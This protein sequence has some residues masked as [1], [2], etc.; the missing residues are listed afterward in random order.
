MTLASGRGC[1]SS[2]AAPPLSSATGN[3]SNRSFPAVKAGCCSPT[4]S[5]IAITPPAEIGSPTR[6]GPSRY[7]HRQP[8]GSTR[9]CPSCAGSSG[10]DA[11]EGR[12]SVRLRLPTDSSVDV[13]KAGEAVHRAESKVALGEWKRAWALSLAALFVA[14]RTFLPG[15]DAPWIDEQRRLLGEIRLR[16]L[17]AYATATLRTGGTELPAAVRAARTLIRVGA[18]SRERLPDVDGGPRRSGQRR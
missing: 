16:A 12:S 9:C 6:C 14:E 17:E 10:W 13:E 5:S 15:E 18:A 7:P 4:W 2:C 3:G 8:R 1:G 11:V